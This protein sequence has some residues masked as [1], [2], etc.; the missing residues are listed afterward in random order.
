MRDDLLTASLGFVRCTV[1]RGSRL[2]SLV[3]IA[4]VLGLALQ[5]HQDVKLKCL[6]QFKNSEE[7]HLPHGEKSS[8]RYE[9]WML[10]LVRCA[11][12]L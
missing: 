7:A 9:S 2:L 5:K 3:A 10:V 4:R 11:T 8:G 12:L 6:F 1:V